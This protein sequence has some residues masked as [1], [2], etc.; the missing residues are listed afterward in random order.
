[1]VIGMSTKFK[2]IILIIVIFCVIILLI[3]L[4]Y[5]Y[6][7][8][9]KDNS[10]KFD[11]INSFFHGDQYYIAV[12]S[13]NNDSY[14][15]AKIS[16]YDEKNKKVW[17]Q[18]Y[19][20]GYNSAFFGVANDGDNIIAVGDY[21]ATKKEHNDSVRS[22]LIVK[23]D[24]DGKMLTE[25]SFQV[26]GD[27]KFT[28]VLVVDDGYIVVGQSIYENMT[29][30]FSNDGG[31]FI[32]KYD[33]ELNEVWKH[34]YGGSKSA[35]Y[36]DLVIV[37]DS[38]YSVGKDSSRLG[39]ISKYTLDGSYISTAT[40]ELT[41]TI[42]FTG[43][44]SDDKNLYIVGSKKVDNDQNDFDTD[45]LIIKYD[46]N[47]NKILENTYDDKGMERYNKIIIDTSSNIVVVGHT[48]IY[49]K[50]MSTDEESIFSYD[51]ILVKYDVD[52]R[53]VFIEKYD[54][55]EDEYF[56]DI[57]QVDDKYLISGYFTDDG[58][59]ISKFITYTKSG[60]LIK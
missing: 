25:K 50:K 38:I 12:G 60:K 19:S 53:E 34:N 56:T 39:I 37:D 24:K 48:G 54:Y 59:Y 33:K 10:F 18:I 35:I 27:S 36:N 47:L 6:F 41:D 49:D 5:Y 4:I 21:E 16:K 43:I 23:Y 46:F 22:A 8:I 30:G 11:S 14:E 28:N 57:K 7:F 31:A 15:R 17:E 58:D 55:G 3:D 29:L 44:A 13:N 51:S 45:A 20:R 40:Y 26:L 2:K 9:K 1:M 42:G 52:L 32:I